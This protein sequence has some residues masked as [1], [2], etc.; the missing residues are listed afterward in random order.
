MANETAL[1]II[2][3]QH[4]FIS[5]ESP[6]CMREVSK[7]I[8]GIKALIAEARKKGWPVIYVIREHDPSGADIEKFRLKYFEKYPFCIT[9]EKGAEVAE[10]IRPEKGD[11]VI[12]K[13]RFSGFFGTKLDLV[14]RRLGIRRLLLCGAQYPNCIRATAVDGIGLDYDVEICP[15]AT[16][17]ASQEVID[18]NIYDMRNMGIK[19]PGIEEIAAE[20]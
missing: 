14:L 18:A 19:F 15:D 13:T 17:G 10:D 1:V 12:G 11:I 6:L 2:D 20:E 5:L 7:I 16:W 4:D 3:M 9:G 8:P